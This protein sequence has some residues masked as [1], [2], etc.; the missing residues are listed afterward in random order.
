MT[1]V[2]RR[3]P[4][5]D[6]H[7]AA[8]AKLVPFAGWDMPVQ[9]EGVRQEHH[10]V[11]TGAGVFDVSHM[12]QIVTR[13]PGALSALQHMTTNDVSKIQ[14]GGAQ[15][16]LI[17][18]PDGGVFDDIFTYRLGEEDY[19]TVT[20]AANHPTDFTWFGH[21]AQ[22][23][24]GELDLELVD[25][26]EDYA[27]LAVQGPKARGIVAGLADIEL[28]KR[29]HVATGNV[30]GVSALICGTGYTGEDGV[31]L[32]VAPADAPAV[33]DALLAAGVTPV[34]LGARDTLRL[35]A[36]YHLYGNDMD[37]GRNAIEAG[38]GWAVKEATGHIGSEATAQFRAESTAEVLVPFSLTETGIPR[39]G[40]PVVGGGVVTS[41]TF[42]PTLEKGVGLAYVPRD[43]SAVGTE[44]TVDVRGK[45]RAAIVEARPLYQSPDLA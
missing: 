36:C 25:A 8:G 27:M 4:L 45:D 3:T 23:G 15:Y 7:V 13:G 22:T 33:W 34:G 44:F 5:Y 2:L 26:A 6:Q 32:L 16:G 24:A 40:N 42:S 43:R 18:R 29:F 39:G 35:E 14:V 20:N 9:Y 28:P 12:G 38:L 37:A 21:H 31:E 17:L 10:A 41:G 30:A 1:A 11:R 19:L